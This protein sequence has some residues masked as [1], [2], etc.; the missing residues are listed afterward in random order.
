MNEIEVDGVVRRNGTLLPE[1]GYV[2]GFPPTSE[3][4]LIPRFD[5]EQIRRVLTDPNRRRPDILFPAEEGYIS[6]Q[7]STS[8][9]AGHATGGLLTNARVLRG[10]PKIILSGAFVY[11]NSK[12]EGQDSGSTLDANMQTIIRL[13]SCRAELCTA[14]MIQ[15]REI[16]KAAYDDA[17]MHK[18]LAA[19]H[20]PTKQDFRT[21]AAAGFPANVVVHAGPNF[22]KVNRN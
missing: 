8:G 17:L 7:L 19:Y 3:S 13:G 20:P 14:N 21:G 16:T 15:R 11:A 9:C 18:G 2:C 22:S 6:D 5:D 12:P 1:L 10:L 4:P